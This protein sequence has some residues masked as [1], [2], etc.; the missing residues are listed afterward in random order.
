MYIC[1]ICGSRIEFH[2]GTNHD[3]ISCDCGEF[4]QLQESHFDNSITFDGESRASG[5]SA[6]DLYY[7]TTRPDGRGQRV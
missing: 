5:Q 6:K 4:D 3:H 7:R 1:S 2:T